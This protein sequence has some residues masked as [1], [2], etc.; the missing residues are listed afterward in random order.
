V[1]NPPY[2]PSTSDELPRTGAR[3]AW[4]AGPDGRVLLDR[5]IDG[6]P[7]HLRPNGVLLV[8]HSTLIGEEETLGRMRAAGLHAEVVERRRGPL[9]P[10][11]QE[12]KRQGVIP[13]HVHDEEVLVLRGKLEVGNSGKSAGQGLHS[14]TALA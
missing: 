9:G 6:A 1:S 3:R 14:R 13:A 10:L 2:V 4:E 7:A 11:M 12:R 5:I 8:T